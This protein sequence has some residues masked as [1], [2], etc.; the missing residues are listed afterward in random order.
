MHMNKSCSISINLESLIFELSKFERRAVRVEST[1][2]R[3]RLADW[4][5]IRNRA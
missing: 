1:E 2:K 5:P 4:K 3:S